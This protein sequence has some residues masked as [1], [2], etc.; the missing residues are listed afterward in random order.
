MMNQNK[1]PIF[2]LTYLLIGGFSSCLEAAPKIQS[3][4]INT[5]QR[6]TFEIVGTGFEDFNGE[7]VSWDDFQAHENGSKIEGLIPIKGHSWS[8][9]GD[10]NST[11]IAIEKQSGSNKALKIEWSVSSETIRAFGWANKGP[12][13]QLYISYWR[14]MSGG[15]DKSKSNHKQFYLYGNVGEFPQAMPFMP[16]GQNRWGFYNN[17]SEGAI[18]AENP[19]PNNINTL[20]WI[21]ENTKDKFQR[22]EFFIKLNE[23]YTMKNGVVEAWLDGQ[24]GIDRHDYRVRNVNGK[25]IDFRLGHLAAG[26]DRSESNPTAWFD[27]VYIATTQARVEVCNNDRYEDCTIKHIQYVDPTNWSPTK[28][29]LNF[30]NMP[31]FKEKNSYVYVIDKNGIPS[32]AFKVPKPS[33]EV[34]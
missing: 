27:D 26:F 24:K 3:I 30:R 19:N 25:F 6:D 22:W 8:R 20:G 11:D 33:W 17:V 29:S 21:W 31:A 12:Y 14:K 18:T 34:F 15:F 2:F 9:L 32:N 10:K 28:I 1:S 4:D 5:S 7:I 23:P 13:D 16:G